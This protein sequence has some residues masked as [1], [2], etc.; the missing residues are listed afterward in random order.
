M[1]QLHPDLRHALRIAGVAAVLGSAACADGDPTTPPSEQPPPLVGEVGPHLQIV[2]DGRTHALLKDSGD[3]FLNLVVRVPLYEEALAPGWSEEQ[4]KALTRPLFEHL[5][6]E[7]DFVVL[8]FDDRQP[9]TALPLGFH[10]RVRND[11][12]GL[13][14]GKFDSTERFLIPPGQLRGISMLMSHA[15][16]RRGPSLHELAHQW[17]QSMLKGASQPH[18]GFVG[19]GG[20]LGGWAPGSLVALEDGIYQGMGPLGV[21]FGTVANR[22]N[23]IPYAPIELFMMGFLPIDSVPPKVEVAVDGVLLAEE[24]EDGKFR[25]SRIDTVDVHEIQKRYGPRDPAVSAAP[26]TF[27]IVYVVVS[28]S[29][30]D[31]DQ[32]D[33]I[34]RDVVEFSRAGPD[35]SGDLLNFWEAT[36]G[37][38][39]IRMDAV[40]ELLQ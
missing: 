34:G 12:D 10:L 29:P 30:L 25:A 19:V 1:I 18:W 13:G 2:Y 15:N 27:R 3:R 31:A 4:A 23:R 14:L 26:R 38:A 9:R 24:G 40:G 32:V 11:V 16:L 6:N 21:P 5:R 20:Q 33:R 39:S 7:M 8:T 22:G 35:D 37:R 36:G 17:G 28:T